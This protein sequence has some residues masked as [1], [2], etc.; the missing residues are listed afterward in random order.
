MLINTSDENDDIIK[1]PHGY[2]L[3][4]F[5]LSL[6]YIWCKLLAKHTDKYN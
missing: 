6:Q 4:T 1:F 5:I 2:D 3:F